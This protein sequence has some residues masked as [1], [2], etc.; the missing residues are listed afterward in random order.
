MVIFVIAIIF[1]FSISFANNFIAPFPM[2]VNN[3][4]KMEYSLHGGQT[5]QLRIS[6]KNKAVLKLSTRSM[7]YLDIMY[8]SV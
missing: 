5:I 6:S 3:M 4:T 7:K 2:Q 8:V 1:I